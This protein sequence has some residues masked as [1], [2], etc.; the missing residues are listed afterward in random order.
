MCDPAVLKKSLDRGELLKAGLGVEWDWE[1]PAEWE[2]ISVPPN[3][4]LN[5]PKT[6]VSHSL[7]TSE[8]PKCYLG[9][10]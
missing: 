8:L 2:K 1:E 7:N 9:R 5:P 6:A 3:L 4:H 10:L